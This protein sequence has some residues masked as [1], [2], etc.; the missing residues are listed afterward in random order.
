LN[1][2]GVRDNGFGLCKSSRFVDP[3]SAS[4]VN[5]RHDDIVM[6]VTPCTENN[7]KSLLC[8]F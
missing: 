5:L 8:V 3:A 1:R 6:A 7:K 2:G 4:D